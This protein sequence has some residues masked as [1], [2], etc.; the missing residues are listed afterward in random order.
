[1]DNFDIFHFCAC[2]EDRTAVF[3]EQLST[4]QGSSSRHPPDLEDFLAALLSDNI[5]T[6]PSLDMIV[7]KG[8]IVRFIQDLYHDDYKTHNSPERVGLLGYSFWFASTGRNAEYVEF[9]MERVVF[10]LEDLTRKSCDWFK[11]K[12]CGVMYCVEVWEIS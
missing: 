9:D 8:I 4:V 1:M 5:F 6:S 10:E 2:N 3:N 11:C 7:N 12:V